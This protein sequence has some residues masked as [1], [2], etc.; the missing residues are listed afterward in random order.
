M[1]EEEKKEEKKKED[2]KKEEPKALVPL[3]EKKVE[4][5]HSLSFKKR[6]LKY[7]ATAGTLVF[8]S[9]TTDIVEPHACFDRAPDGGS[10]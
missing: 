6:A 9:L 7:T 8:G 3:E 1:A 5:K 10:R 4:T 2:E